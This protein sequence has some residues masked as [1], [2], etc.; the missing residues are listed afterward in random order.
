M[1]LQWNKC[2][3]SL[4]KKVDDEHVYCLVIDNTKGLVIRPYNTRDE[5]WDDEDADDYYCDASGSKITKWVTL[6]DL[7]LLIER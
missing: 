7:M 1:T 6:E 3:D 2:E 5:C 4:P